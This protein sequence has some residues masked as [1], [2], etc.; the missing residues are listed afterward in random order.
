MMNWGFCI[1]VVVNLLR[2][3]FVAATLI[4][5]Y[6][7]FSLVE[8]GESWLGLLY[9]L[10]LLL[11]L[12]HFVSGWLKE[13]G[14]ENLDG[15][16]EKWGKRLFMMQGTALACWAFDIFTTFYAINVTHLASEINPLGW[17]LGIVGALIFYCPT[18]LFSHILMSRINDRLSFFVVT[19]ISSLM[20][21]MG[22][23]NLLAGVQ[24]LAFFLNTVSLPAALRYP[25]LI[26]ILTVDLVFVVS[27]MYG[28]KNFLH[29]RSNPGSG[30]S[31]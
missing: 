7:I 30:N 31:L 20:F 18:L 4:V 23:L 25:F 8:V 3:F 10:I 27:R 6:C 22:L 1:T 15:R 21:C 5:V 12:S 17:P 26:M 24:N 2:G 13:R 9:F 14:T 16:S 19:A 28:S 11:P 29:M